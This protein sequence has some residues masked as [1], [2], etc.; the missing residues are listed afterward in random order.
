MV[1]R[2]GDGAAAAAGHSVGRAVLPRAAGNSF[3][4]TAVPEIAS[5]RCASGRSEM[6]SLQVSLVE[7]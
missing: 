6:G 4:G 3:S 1:D 7:L 2:A 5:Y